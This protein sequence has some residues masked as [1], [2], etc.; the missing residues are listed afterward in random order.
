MKTLL[1]LLLVASIAVANVPSRQAASDLNYIATED[2]QCNTYL[3]YATNSLYLMAQAEKENNLK[4]IN[5]HFT[6]FQS[7]SDKAIEYCRYI[8][9]EATLEL[10]E[11]Q[12]A[13]NA[14]YLRNYYAKDESKKT[15]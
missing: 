7:N 5:I 14:Y 6:N 15:K 12:L 2:T 1:S 9:E 4:F 10:M 8:N 3:E 13:I 11:I